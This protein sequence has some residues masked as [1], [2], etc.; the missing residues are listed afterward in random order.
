MPIKPV[1]A[2]L[3]VLAHDSRLDRPSSETIS[4]LMDLLYYGDFRIF[5]QVASADGFDYVNLI[6]AKGP[7]QGEKPLW[8]ISPVATGQLPHPN[9]WSR[10]NGDPFQ[11]R[12]DNEFGQLYGLGATGGKIDFVCKLLAASTVSTEELNRP[13]YVIGLF[14]EEA[15]ATGLTSVLDLSGGEGGYAL[16]GAPTNLA[17][18]RTHPG[19]VSL[20]ITLHREVR[21][22]RMP[23]IRGIFR[24]FVPGRSAHAQWPGLAVNALERSFEILA[25]LNKAGEIRILELST[26]RG[27]NRIPGHCTITIATTYETP[28]CVPDDVTIEE[29]GDGTSVPFPVDGLVAFWQRGKKAVEKHFDQHKDFG[30]GSGISSDRLMHFGELASER[31]SISGTITFWTGNNAA[32]ME[33][34]SA[35][36]ECFNRAPRKGDQVE[37]E[38]QVIQDRPYFE[39]TEEQSPFL[40]EVQSV[41]KDQGLAPILSRGLLTTD[42]GL[43]TQEGIEAFAFGPGT[44]G[45][46]LYRDDESVPLE[47]ITACYQFYVEL[48]RRLCIKRDRP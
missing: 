38:I 12:I 14:G 16:V 31:D 8:L 7:S 22:R 33:L 35:V 45:S 4:Y 29:L 18:C 20:R 44:S 30:D 36:A 9:Q 47:H 48:I 17:L 24:L 11:P 19:I 32:P 27:A 1:K 15:R 34:A 10:T 41:L 46:S 23:P 3:E 25:D 26:D 37:V 5:Q 13:L 43:L 28:P 40:T 6:G 21:H 2:A 39:A 42:C